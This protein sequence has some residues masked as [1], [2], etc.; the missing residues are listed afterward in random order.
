MHPAVQ[1]ARQRSGGTL[2]RTCIPP[3]CLSSVPAHRKPGL[4]LPKCITTLLPNQPATTAPPARQLPRRLTRL[5]IQLRRCLFC[6]LSLPGLDREEVEGGVDG[7]G[8][9]LG[10]VEDASQS[11]SCR[12]DPA[13]GGGHHLDH[14]TQRLG[15][16]GAQLQVSG[17]HQEGSCEL[18]G[19]SFYV[20]G[21]DGGAEG[22][23]GCGLPAPSTVAAAQQRCACRVPLT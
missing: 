4:E 10:G 16:L 13:V 6:G 14:Y 2:V 11:C 1:L 17:R 20:G 15:G 21:C 3:L 22:I 12:F 8:C 18:D 23:C 19:E 5:R 9:W 7:L